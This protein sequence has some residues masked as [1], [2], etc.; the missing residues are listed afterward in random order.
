MLPKAQLS[1]RTLWS[2]SVES[3]I[4][5]TPSTCH[6]LSVLGTKLGHSAILTILNVNEWKSVYID[7]TD[8]DSANCYCSGHNISVRI[9]DQ[10]SVAKSCLLRRIESCL[11][12]KKTPA[13]LIWRTSFQSS[14]KLDRLTP[15]N[16]NKLTVFW[17]GTGAMTYT[18]L[19]YDSWWSSWRLE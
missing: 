12:N 10:R 13:M 9:S 1:H 2:T 18:Y 5:G 6:R 16:P 19:Y 11:K 7:T 4:D 15:C 14:E 3:A 8:S 17:E